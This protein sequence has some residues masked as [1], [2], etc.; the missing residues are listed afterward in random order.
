MPFLRDESCHS[1]S[2]FPVFIFTIFVDSHPGCCGFV[3]L[4]NLP[5]ASH[6]STSWTVVRVINIT[7]C[8]KLA[9]YTCTNLAGNKILIHILPRESA[10]RTYEVEQE[11]TI[12]YTND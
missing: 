1:Q 7:S 3:T 12:R 2:T 5:R 10:R 9:S 11:T 6:H 8:I 4:C